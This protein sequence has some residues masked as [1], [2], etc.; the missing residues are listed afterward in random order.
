MWAPAP[1]I[2]MMERANARRSE[3][4]TTGSVLGFAWGEAKTH[5]LAFAEFL[6]LKFFR[7]WYSTATRRRE[8]PI[9]L[10]QIFYVPLGV[11][12]LFWGKKRYPKQTLAMGVFVS[13]VVYFWAMALLTLPIFRYLV[14]AFGYVII[15]VAIAIEALIA[16]V[17]SAAQVN[18]V[19]SPR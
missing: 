10:L 6:L 7:P 2:G 16:S 17:R 5:P 12:G 4:Q 13:V 15:F 3:M 19:P 9:V 8:S 11:A 1:V 18:A 14:P